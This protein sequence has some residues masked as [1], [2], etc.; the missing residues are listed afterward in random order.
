MLK[1]FAIAAAMVLVV[2]SVDASFAAPAQSSAAGFARHAAMARPRPNPRFNHRFFRRDRDFRRNAF[3]FWG[4]PGWWPDDEA[5][6]D[7]YPVAAPYPPPPMA[8][9]RA[10]APPPCPLLLQWDPKLGH[11]TRQRL[12]D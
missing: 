9:A 6:G 8:A 10:V 3:W 2:G 7:A 4:W 5:P 12:C 1:T 11:E